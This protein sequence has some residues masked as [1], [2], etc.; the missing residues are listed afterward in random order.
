MRAR[1]GLRSLELR[2]ERLVRV[3]EVCALLL[4]RSER[5]RRGRGRLVLVRRE[6]R[7]LAYVRYPV[8]L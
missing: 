3:L 6:E 8:R 1:T 4:R 5:V 2:G 7:R